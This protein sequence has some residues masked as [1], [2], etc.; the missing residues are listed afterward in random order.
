VKVG[1]AA[2]LLVASAA[3]VACSS[4]PK[5]AEL[6]PVTPQ[7]AGRGVWQARVGSIGFPL[8]VAARDGR[9]FAAG[10][11]GTVVSFEAETGREVW[12]AQAGGAVSAG[13]GS[14]GRYT[15]VVTVSNEVV[16][17]DGAQPAWRAAL[18]SRTMTAPLVAGERVFVLT[19]DR[20]VHAFDA[21]D[22]RRL[23]TLQRPGDPLTLG[24]AGA[25]A[26]YRDT[27]LVGQGVRLTAI[28][29]LRGSVRWEVPLANPRG[30]NEVERLADLI[31]PP[32]RVGK[33]FCLR[34]FQAAV[35]CV[36]AERGLI[37]WSR[38]AGGVQAVAAD[39][40]VVV[41]ADASDRITAWRQSSGEVLWSSEKLL[42]RSLSGAA[43]AGRTVVFGDLQGQLHFLDRGD[44]KPL[45]RLP[46][47]GTAVVG[48]PSVSGVTML[49]ATRGGGLFAFRPE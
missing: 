12:R 20:I 28:D 17:F 46:T 22:G 7:I 4:K 35:G 23:W 26:A 34:A 16:V 44:G 6:E 42:N 13:V 36:D 21:R 39:E 25:L 11:D 10:D 38:N 31:G 43:I 14:D 37:Q 3:L 41:G 32:A 47:D 24:Q 33:V 5:P 30:T 18:S 45:L 15:A 19:V 27:L 49:V 9:F 8:T 1:A 2:L 29:P 48:V 40:N